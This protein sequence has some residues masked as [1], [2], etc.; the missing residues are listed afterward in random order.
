ML[1]LYNHKSTAINKLERNIYKSLLNNF[2]GR[3]TI[4]IKDTLTSI[5]KEDKFLTLNKVKRVSNFTQLGQHVLTTYSHS[6]DFDR[7]NKFG[8]DKFKVLNTTNNNK[9]II[10]GYASI[11]ITVAINSY[12]RI[13]INEIKHNLLNKNILLYYTDTDSIYIDKQLPIH[14]VSNDKLGLFKQEHEI[15]N[16]WFISNKLY[17]IENIDKTIKTV[18]KGINK[19]ILKNDFITLYKGDNITI[20]T[21]KSFKHPTHILFNNININLNFNAYTKR[22]KVYRNKKWVNT[23]PILIK[24]I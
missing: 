23:K 9:P 17:L 16:A 8:L 11:I 19:P 6:L 18:T 21:I 2:L 4:T 13:Y 1:E 3:W 20:P 10:P 22:I 15:K 24:S 5:I 14:L 12:A 7:I